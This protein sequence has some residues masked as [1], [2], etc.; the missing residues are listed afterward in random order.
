MREGPGA[1]GYS[2]LHQAV[3]LSEPLCAVRL[4]VMDAPWLVEDVGSSRLGGGGNRDTRSFAACGGHND[5][6]WNGWASPRCETAAAVP[7]DSITSGC[8]A[9]GESGRL[10]FIRALAVLGCNDGWIPCCG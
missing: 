10:D 6:P 2:R 4:P 3:L 9:S 7:W 1:W 8:I 5:V